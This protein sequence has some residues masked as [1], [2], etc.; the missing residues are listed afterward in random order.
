MAQSTNVPSS[1][2]DIRQKRRARRRTLSSSASTKSTFSSQYEING[3]VLGEGAY[4]SVYKCN[5]IKTD[6]E[7]AVKIISKQGQVA[8]KVVREIE[9]YYQCQDAENILHLVELFE[10]ENRFYLVFELIRG[11]SLEARIAE[12]GDAGRLPERSVKSLVKSIASALQFLHSKGIAHRDI[13]PANILL[14]NSK[15][16]EGAKLCDFDLASRSRRDPRHP[17]VRGDLCMTSPVGS[18]EFMAPEVVRAFTASYYERV[19]YDQQC[20]I[21]S[22]GVIA[23]S[24]LSGKAPFE[25]CCGKDCD[26]EDGGAC[27]DCMES[28]FRNI[29][30]GHLRF[31]ENRWNHISTEA[32]NLISRCLANDPRNRPSPDQ[33]LNHKW[34]TAD[35]STERVKSSK[36]RQSSSTMPYDE[37]MIST[38]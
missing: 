3:K 22:L 17:E 2:I 38:A 10:D 11:G 27:D 18:A 9:V 6:I 30:K 35:N 15:S 8:K 25:G 24:L 28:L 23:Y 14:P 32:I 33:I 16:L 29:Q 37:I 31:P 13:K 19:R 7:Y 12:I 1:P 34:F 5:H 26:W 4:G 20:D 21:W 36:V